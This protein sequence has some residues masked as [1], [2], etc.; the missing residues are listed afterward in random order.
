MAGVDDGA[1]LRFRD[2]DAAGRIGEEV[3]E[4]NEGGSEQAED[5]Q[6]GRCVRQPD[7]DVP[8]PPRS[9]RR[10]WGWRLGVGR[11]MHVEGGEMVVLPGPG[12]LRRQFDGLDVI[13]L[14]S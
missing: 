8:E 3:G 1:F 10:G 12:C 5:C 6:P 13:V 4:R 7:Q 2:A 14:G 11:G 9:R